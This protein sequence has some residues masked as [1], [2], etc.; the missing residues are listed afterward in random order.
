VEGTALG[1]NRRATAVAAYLAADRASGRCIC[2]D[3]QLIDERGPR[4]FSQSP[5]SRRRDPLRCYGLILLVNGDAT[6]RAA[7]RTTRSSSLCTGDA[8]HVSYPLGHLVALTLIL[9]TGNAR[10]VNGPLKIS[11]RN[12][13]VRALKILEDLPLAPYT[14]RRHTH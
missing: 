6:R 13:A 9:M 10:S 2:N 14:C 8:G 12:K 11:T 1:F 7:P 4:D 5:Q 3:A